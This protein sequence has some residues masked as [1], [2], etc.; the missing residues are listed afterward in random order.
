VYASRSQL[1]ARTVLS[2]AAPYLGGLVVAQIGGPTTAAFSVTTSLTVVAVHLGIRKNLVDNQLQAITGAAGSV[3]LAAV[4]LS[5]GERTQLAGVLTVLAVGSALLALQRRGRGAAVVVSAASVAGSYWSLLPE[6]RVVELAT[7][8]VAFVWCLVG[9]VALRRTTLRSFPLLGPGL[10]LASV[11][12]VIELLFTGQTLLRTLLLVAVATAVALVGARHRL[13]TPII[14]GVSTALAAAITQVGPW[15]I[16]LPRWL[17][18]G[19][20]G[21]ALLLAGARFE[22]L[23]E[24]LNSTGAKLIA[25]R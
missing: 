12:S 16:G 6:G 14:V 21:V 4:L 1:A 25:L 7:L 22:T 20:A 3:A 9:I 15:A 17:T 5:V 18:L 24:R 11:P 23:R 13:L 2:A 19:C 10:L 8:P